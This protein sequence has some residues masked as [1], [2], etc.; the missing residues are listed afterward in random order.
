M[1]VFICAFCGR[2]LPETK[3]DEDLR[4]DPRGIPPA[5]PRPAHGGVQHLLGWQSLARLYSDRA[6]NDGRGPPDHHP[7]H[8]RRPAGE[9]LPLDEV[10]QGGG[11]E[12]NDLDRTF[13]NIDLS[14]FCP[15]PGNRLSL[16]REGLGQRFLPK[17]PDGS[18]P[19]SV[20]FSDACHPNF[21]SRYA[22]FA[23][24]GVYERFGRERV[25]TLV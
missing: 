20:A 12:F 21:T 1:T 2:T 10:C 19:I 18:L 7:H 23:P 8:C 5:I 11:G 13:G 17:P 14:L 15:R 24:N 6:D 4:G 16:R 22:K 3:R 25:T 9:G